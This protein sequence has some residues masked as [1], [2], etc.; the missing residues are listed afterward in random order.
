MSRKDKIA[1][2]E[3]VTRRKFIRATAIAGAAISVPWVFATRNSWGQFRAAGTPSDDVLAAFRKAVDAFNQKD[4][5]TLSPLLDTAVLLKKIHTG[6]HPPQYKG[7]TAVMDYLKGAWNGNPPVT[8]IFDPFGGG[9]TPHVQVQGPSNTKAFV[10][11]DAC[12]KDNDGDDADGQLSYDFQFQNVGG[13]WLV[14]EL[15]GIY[16]GKP[17]PC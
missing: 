2:G 13:A 6:H 10:K 16:T 9:Q 4:A 17:N 14:T 1:S 3:K 11:G 8:M 5:A 7:R 12:W 15:S